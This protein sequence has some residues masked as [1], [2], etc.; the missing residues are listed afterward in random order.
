MIALEQQLTQVRAEEPAPP[1]TTQVLM[2]S[3][4]R[5][6]PPSFRER[7]SRRWL[8]ACTP[9]PNSSR[10][11]SSTASTGGRYGGSTGISSC[12]PLLSSMFIRATPTR[13]TPRSSISGIA[14]AIS[15][16][17]EASTV[18]EAA[19]GYSSVLDRDTR[20]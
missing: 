10:T 2:A 17:A 9:D 1:V 11:W 18:R 4:P 16:R 5:P 20:L 6:A 13:V 7:E 14:S 3:Q 12:T 8:D 19:V 15:T